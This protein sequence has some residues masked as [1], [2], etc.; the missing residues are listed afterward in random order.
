MRVLE[1]FTVRP[2]IAL[3]IALSLQPTTVAQD[4]DEVAV[5]HA[6]DEIP[7]S[8]L[9]EF[10]I[11]ERDLS[12]EYDP[13]KLDDIVTLRTGTGV[14]TASFW[15]LTNRM[16]A[17]R[18]LACIQVS[19]EENLTIVPLSD[20]PNLAR[21][22][23][24]AEQAKAGY[25]KVIREIAH[26]K[27]ADL[28]PSLEA[29]LSGQESRVTVLADSKHVLL[30]GL[31]PR[32]LQALTLLSF[33]DKPSTTSTVFEVALEHVHPVGLVTLVE[34]ILAAQGTGNQ[35]PRGKVLANPE[36]HGLIVV[37]PA[38]E[39]RAW[40]DLIQRFDRPERAYTIHYIP[41]RFGLKET[42]AL[43]EQVLAEGP[44]GHEKEELR[45]VPDLLTST[46]I[47]TA[48]AS[49]HAR[50]EELMERMASVEVTARRVLRSIPVRNRNAA[51]LLNLLQELIGSQV[52]IG[53]DGELGAESP[54]SDQLAEEGSTGGRPSNYLGLSLEELSLAADEGTNHL[55][56][57]GEER[58]LDQLETLVETLDVQHP[59]VLLEVLILSL[60]ESDT[61]DLGAELR[62]LIPS[63]DDRIQLTSLF[64]LGAADPAGST[65]PALMG[66][67]FS[68]AVLDPGSFS[69]LV[70]ALQTLNDGRSLT[71]P[72]VL[73]SNNQ[74]AS[75]NSV[76]QSPFT[77]TNASDTVATTSFGGTLDAG[78]SIAVRPQI[79]E[80]DKVI[81][82][83]TVSISAF[84]GDSA[85][86][87]LPP[88]REESQLQSVVTIPDGF[89][90]VLGGLE[91]ESQTDA[92]SQVPLLGALPVLGPL[93]RSRSK[94]ST[95]SRFFLFIRA[96][97]VRGVGL[98]ELKHASDLALVDAD[99]PPNEPAL[100]PRII[101]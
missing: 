48:T 22:E 46:L 33:L 94:T 19:G 30:A 54:A 43:I 56:A 11:R 86:P 31:K 75:L 28:K 84:T 96:S 95:R 27:P 78:T 99:L 80:G 87:S 38:S 49:Q 51:D 81:L 74:E 4:D 101:R 17:A 23:P 9:M 36:G 77:S 7:L 25:V 8:D 68:G 39:A 21:L 44:L 47:I 32:V 92:T 15:A 89:T 100:A 66:G 42:Q 10:W 73:V 97:T 93:F 45:I 57:L 5:W 40:R 72:K 90:A 55:L 64:G 76:L 35:N 18:G 34:R 70:R 91:I 67:G 53:S 71:V 26:A 13:E 2:T 85:D 83:Y 52:L 6:F 59:Q 14:T 20:A 82:D 79:V 98:Q 69:A 24:D 12:L 88:P 50:I 60:S 1:H 16:L 61:L 37:A 63:G 41:P 3:A 29:V 62:S 65:L 58:W